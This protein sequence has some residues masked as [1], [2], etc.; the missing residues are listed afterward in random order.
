M[1][2]TLKKVIA[3]LDRIKTPMATYFRVINVNGASFQETAQIYL[4]RWH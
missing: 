3:N 2:E 4:K 1:R